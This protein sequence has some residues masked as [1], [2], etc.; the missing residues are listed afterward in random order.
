MTVVA[1]SAAHKPIFRA[2]GLT[3]NCDIVA[4]FCL[5]IA[6][7]IPIHSH[8]LDELESIHVGLIVLGYISSH[9]EG[10]VHRHIQC[11]LSSQRGAAIAM[12]G[13]IQFGTI[14]FEDT[15]CIVHRATNQA[16]KR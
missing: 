9:L 15:W 13:W 7:F 2:F 1:S 5:K 4:W 16:G 6:A 12:I 11:Q 14:H 8:I 3:G 10:T